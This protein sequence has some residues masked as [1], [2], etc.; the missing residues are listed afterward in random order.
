MELHRAFKNLTTPKM[1]YEKLGLTTIH[2]G[3]IKMRFKKNQ[4]SDDKM[5]ELLIRS[6]YKKISDEQWAKTEK[7][8]YFNFQESVVTKADKML[9]SIESKAGSS[10]IKIRADDEIVFSGSK[11]ELVELIGV[12]LKK[13]MPNRAD[14]S[15]TQQF[16]KVTLNQL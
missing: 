5:R 11:K 1:W 3:M 15:I 14:T 10:H 7:K 16:K 4:L 2:A 8:I 12:K 13:R 9:F 6:G